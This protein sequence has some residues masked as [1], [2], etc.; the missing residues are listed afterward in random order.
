MTQDVPVNSVDYA[1]ARKT[2]CGKN[3][4][5]RGIAAQATMTLAL[6]DPSRNSIHNNKLRRPSAVRFGYLE[7]KQ[8]PFVFQLFEVRCDEFIQAGGSASPMA[9]LPRGTKH[10]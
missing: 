10:L 1:A 6:A 7:G 4:T 2:V 8:D 5:V 9:V 3:A